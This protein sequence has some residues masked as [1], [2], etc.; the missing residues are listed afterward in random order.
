MEYVIA[1]VEQHV[2]PRQEMF[3]LRD[4]NGQK[5]MNFFLETQ[6]KQKHPYIYTYICAL[7]PINTHTEYTLSL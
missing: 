6:Y 4:Q 1:R 2:P 3:S 5:H 7:I